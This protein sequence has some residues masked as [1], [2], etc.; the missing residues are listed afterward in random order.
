[1]EFQLTESQRALQ[2]AARKY[3]REVVRPK[4]AHYDETSDFPRDL[5]SA[6]FELGLLNMAI[7]TE[8][9]GVGLSHLEQVIVC[10]E[11]AWGCAGVATSII[12]NDLA[13][14]P[15]ILHGTDDQK[16][17]LL[18][19]FGQKLKFSSF[20]LTEPSAGSDVAAL[21]TTARL[22]GDEYVLNG[23][24]CFIT[25]G[26]YADQFT[27]FATLDKGRKHKGITC[28]VVEGRPQGLTTG[29]HENK[30]GQRASN[31]TTVTFDEVRVPVANRIG[32]EG[33][34]FKVAMATLDN[35]RPLT[36]SLSVG[37]ARAALEH[38]LEYSS[39]RHTFGK[40]IREHQGV[41]FMLA[42][43]AMN[44]HAARLLTWESAWVLDEGQRNTLQSSYAKC[45]AAD[46]A[47][48]VATDAVQVYGGYGYMKE[49][50]VEKLMRDAKLIQVYEGTS[51][52]QRLVIAKELFR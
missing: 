46:M 45:F 18:A 50:P 22:E 20:C 15:I 3:A 52:V 40:P 7:P 41:Q 32:E 14:L 39:Q 35:S 19:P 36:A 26:G 43:M 23:S 12:A 28:F 4:A 34:G 33:E 16:K 1:M 6:A 8:Y 17:R 42:D 51:Q 9:G 2:D 27:V 24:K 48:K 5:L 47:M 25:N 30:M 29:K 37:I 49:Y 13:N 21:S 11:L 31:T 38:S 10:E 44:T